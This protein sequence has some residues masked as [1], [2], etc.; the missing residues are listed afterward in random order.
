[1]NIEKEY[2]MNIKIEFLKDNEIDSF[3]ELINDAFSIDVSYDSIKKSLYTDNIKF[4]CA[5]DR[6]RIV[7]TIM[8]TTDF[9][10]VKNIKSFYLDYVSVLSSYQNKKIG[11]KLMLEVEKFAKENNISYIEFTSSK[12]RV[13]ARKLYSS[14]GYEERDTDVFFKRI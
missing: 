9:D 8:I 4:L 11:S 6:E 12:K 2:S 10:P 1:M 3:I 14:C 13:N 7:G 5:K